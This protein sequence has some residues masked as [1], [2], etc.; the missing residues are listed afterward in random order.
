MIRTSMTADRTTPSVHT[1]LPTS[2]LAITPPDVHNTPTINKG[3]ERKVIQ[4]DYLRAVEGGGRVVWGF[5]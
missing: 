5:L 1:N 3:K 2:A 4:S